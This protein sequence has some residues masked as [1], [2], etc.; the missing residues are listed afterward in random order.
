MEKRQVT[1]DGTYSKAEHGH[2]ADQSEVNG[3]YAHA[4]GSRSAKRSS[5]RATTETKISLKDM[6]KLKEKVD[7]CL[8]N[9]IEMDL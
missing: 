9:N 3:D 7:Q 5:S 1:S 2:S 4:S 8:A 6:E